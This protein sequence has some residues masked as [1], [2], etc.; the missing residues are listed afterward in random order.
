MKTQTRN[1]TD[2]INIGLVGYGR[3]GKVVADEIYRQEDVLLTCIFKKTKDQ[4]FGKDIGMLHGQSPNGH[5]IHHI[6]DLEGCLKHGI[7]DVVIDF[8]HPD[9]VVSYI[10]LLCTYGINVVICSTNFKPEQREFVNRR[11][12]TIGIVWAPNVTE[13]INILMYLGRIVKRIWPES[14]I[15]IIEYHFSKKKDVSKTAV[16][17]AEAITD[18]DAIKVGR[19]LDEPRI[20]KETVIHTVRVGGIIG[21]HSIVIGQPHQTL[22]ITHE[23]IDRYAFGKG[24]LKAARWIKGKKG[25]FTMVDVLQL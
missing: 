7:I 20:G 14:D 1:E 8:S 13:G 10:D 17:I 9:A 18:D 11:C 3:T 4:Y 5:F 12:D 16:K 24:A 21:K 19:S 22:T 25:L 23:S 2:M 15:E 6:S